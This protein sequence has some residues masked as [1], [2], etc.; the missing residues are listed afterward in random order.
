MPAWR[1]TDNIIILFIINGIIMESR[2]LF[3]VKVFEVNN[4]SQED[5]D[6]QI[7]SKEI[8][9]FPNMLNAGIIKV[10]ANLFRQR[11]FP[12]RHYTK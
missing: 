2:D 7:D 11:C 12:T 4:S 1:F 5:G 9:Q 3:T 6:A 10:S 8:E